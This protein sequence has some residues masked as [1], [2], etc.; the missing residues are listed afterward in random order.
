MFL[1]LSYEETF[2]LTTAEA[3]ACG[4][5]SVV[6]NVTACPELISNKTGFVV[7]SQNIKQLF[8]TIKLAR[9]LGKSKFTNACR[10]RAIS[11]FDKK[12]LCKEYFNLYNKILINNEKK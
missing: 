1:N 2:G 11:L 3:L 8:N 7:E 12:R 5:P 10:N 9:D 4:V 6:Y